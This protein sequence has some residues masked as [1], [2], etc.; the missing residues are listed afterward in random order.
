MHQRSHCHE[1]AFQR[2][3][4]LFFCDCIQEKSTRCQLHLFLFFP[5]FSHPNNT[6]PRGGENPLFIV[7]GS[8]VGDEVVLRVTLTKPFP[9]Y[10]V[11]IVSFLFCS[12]FF[13]SLCFHPD[14]W[15]RTRVSRRC[16]HQQLQF[17]FY[18]VFFSLCS[19][20][21]FFFLFFFASV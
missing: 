16:L 6:L 1:R 8:V 9:H 5:S 20:S 19:L 11:L 18:S 21:F 10:H 2:H 14:G 12:R 3:I 15:H 13:F 17:L 4:L 7:F